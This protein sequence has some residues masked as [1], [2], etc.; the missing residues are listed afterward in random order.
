MF[1]TVLIANRGE[2]AVRVARTLKK[3]G[4][5]SV[6]VY[7]DADRNSM[8]V[9]VADVAVNIGGA[10]STDSYL[11]GD[12]VIEAAKAAGAQ[13]IFPGYGFLSENADFCEACTQAGLVFIGPTAQHMREFGLKHAARAI[14]EKAGVPT[15]PGSGLLDDVNQAIVEAKRIGYPV[16][17]KSTAGGGGIGLIRCADEDELKNAFEKAQRL[18]K[19]YFSDGRVFVERLLV[20]ARHTEVQ[21]FGDGKGAVVALGERDCSI[22][23]KNQKIIEETPAPNLPDE[24]RKALLSVSEKLGRSVNYL[25]AG[26]IEYL[27]DEQRNEFFFLEVNTR[28]QVEHCVTE[29]VTGIDL[30]EWMIATAG[31]SPPNLK[32]LPPPHGASIEVRLLAE[33]PLRGFLPSPGV[34]TEVSFPTDARIDGYVDTGTEVSSHYDS[35]IAKLIVSAETREAAIAKLS[36]ALDATRLCGIATNLEYLRKIVATD[37]FRA[38]QV[39]T[40]FLD[41]FVFIAPVIEVLEPGTFTTI[42]DYPGRVGYWDIGLPPSGPMDEY[43]FQIANSLLGNHSSAAALEAT[44]KSTFVL[45]QMG[46]HGGRTLRSYDLLSISAKEEKTNRH[47]GKITAFPSSLIPLYGQTWEIRALYGPHGAPDFFTEESV[48]TFFETDWQVHYNSN[49]LGVRLIGPKPTWTRTDGGEA[50]LHPSNVH[51]CEYAIGTVNFTGDMPVILTQ[52]GPSLGGFVCLVTIAKAELW[53][54]GQVKPGDTIRFVPISFDEAVEMEKRQ[55]AIIETLT[56]SDVT[57]KLSTTAINWALTASD[58]GQSA[59]ILATIRKSASSPQVVYRQAGDKYILIEYG[60]VILDLNL[61]FQVHALMEALQSSPVSGILELSPGV[62]SLQ[63]HYD[64]LIIGQQELL[65]KLITLERQLPPVASMKV[66]SRVVHLPMVFEDSA[67]LDAVARYR[68]SVRDTAPWLP[69]NTEFIRRING[70]DS[71]QQVRDIIYKTSYM[72]LGLGDVYLGAPCAVPVDPRHRLLTSKYN[73]A[74]TYT[75]EGTVGIGGIYMCIYGMDSPGG[76]QLVGRTLPIWNKFLKNKI[77]SDGKPWLLRF[78]DQVRFYPVEEVRLEEMRSAFRDGR[79]SIEITEEVFDLAEYNAFLESIAP[80]L[81]SFKRKQQAAFEIE[82]AH[83]KI[84]EAK[85]TTND[86]TNDLSQQQNGTAGK[87]QGMPVAADISGNVWKLAAQPGDCV[88]TGDTL[89]ILEAMKMEFS[90]AAPCDGILGNF[91]CRA[92]TQV[93]A[94]DILVSVVEHS[95]L[96]N[97]KQLKTADHMLHGKEIDRHQIVGR[98]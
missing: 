23:R 92:G 89:L 16:M 48:K 19:S 68:Q 36:L 59:A 75:A 42:Q 47:N 55:K 8:H 43:A 74:R 86:S 45:G 3:M 12:A 70:L 7:S 91:L 21:I 1:D 56:C 87:D 31:G 67:T 40:A 95:D 90:V 53:K 50:G 65:K 54:V 51:D 82:V 24:T 79:E 4:I 34:L 10:A 39:S 88:K 9:K 84:D 44:F 25:S 96:S 97:E 98:T 5:R 46:G 52:D 83:W 62:R 80:E 71:V 17:V 28:L 18:A 73:P 72:V 30:V 77:F 49:R 11:R 15:M 14:A 78:F 64:S 29:E 35:L 93:Q 37:A 38:G 22:Q 60:P 33:N 41:S 2:I 27:Y 63:I 6:A 69:S 58:N 81:D 61:R 85:L 94:G 26:S 76:Y 20:H 57:K 66:K 32:N 13:A